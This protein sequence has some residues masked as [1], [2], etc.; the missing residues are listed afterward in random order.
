MKIQKM[1]ILLG[2]NMKTDV[3]TMPVKYRGLLLF[4][5]MI[6]HRRSV[7]EYTTHEGVNLHMTSV[8]VY[9]LT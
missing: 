1:F 3:V 7:F 8:L 9:L 4:N 6:P 2:A 5:N